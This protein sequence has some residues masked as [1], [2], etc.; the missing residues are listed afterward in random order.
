MAA[1]DEVREEAQDARAYLSAKA[2][3]EFYVELP[4]EESE[5]QGQV[6]NP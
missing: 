5:S 1:T 3:R 4:D 6:R 2:A